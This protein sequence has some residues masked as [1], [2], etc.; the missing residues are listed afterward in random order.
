MLSTGKQER[1]IITAYRDSQRKGAQLGSYTAMFNPSSVRRTAGNLYRS[2]QALNS[3][4]RPAYFAYAPPERIELKIIVDGTLPGKM[5]SQPS[6]TIPFRAQVTDVA[7]SVEQFLHLTHAVNPQTRQPNYLTLQMGKTLRAIACRL[8][9]YSIEYSSLDE[10]GNAKRAEITATFIEEK[11]KSRQGLPLQ[12]AAADNA[13]QHTI[14]A[15]DTLPML[16]QKHYGSSEKL[17]GLARFNRLN[18][19]RSLALGSVLVVPPAAKEGID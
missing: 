12:S 17:V 11:K 4:G 9:Q 13:T 10:Q 14:K 2:A 15:G 6:A 1:L 18:S 3:G 7:Q 19:L 8:A 5:L 16:A